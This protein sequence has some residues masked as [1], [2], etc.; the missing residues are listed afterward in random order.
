MGRREDLET[1]FFTFFQKPL[2]FVDFWTKTKKM[3]ERW[4]ATVI[5]N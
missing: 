3:K 2:L 5:H 4:R 1:N